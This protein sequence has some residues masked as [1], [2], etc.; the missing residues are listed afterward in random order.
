[1]N[2]G[3]ITVQHSSV[4]GKIIGPYTGYGKREV[5]HEQKAALEEVAVETFADMVSAGHTFQSA[6][7]AIYYTGIVHAL[8]TS[9]AADRSTLSE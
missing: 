9:A 4:R 6:L 2:R 7:A 3:Q 1:M 5:S 8:E